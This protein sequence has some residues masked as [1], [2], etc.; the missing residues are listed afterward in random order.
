MHGA[1]AAEGLCASLLSQQRLQPRDALQQHPARATPTRLTGANSDTEE[2]E[3]GDLIQFYN[4]IYI[5]QIKEFALKYTSSG[6]R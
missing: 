4:S 3:R 5:E 6:V 2:E 1:A